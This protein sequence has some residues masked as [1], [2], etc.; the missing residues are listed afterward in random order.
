VI[1]IPLYD[2]SCACGYKGEHIAKIDEMVKCPD[3]NFEMK[4]EMPFTHGINM[5][6]AGATG[7][8]DDNLQTYIHSNRQRREEMKRQGVAETYGKGWY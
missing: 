2:Y 3:C 5:G 8:Y 4:R 7:Y 6:A 1:K